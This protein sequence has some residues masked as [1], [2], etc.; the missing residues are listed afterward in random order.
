MVDYKYGISAC[1]IVLRL[2]DSLPPLIPEA[3]VSLTLIYSYL[4]VVSSIFRVRART[5]LLL[6]LIPCTL[7]RLSFNLVL[8][9]YVN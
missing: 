6:Q 1:T 5:M 2:I 3:L 8:L 7:S 4:G 9:I